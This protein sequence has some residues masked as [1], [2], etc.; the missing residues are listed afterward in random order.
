M[1]EQLGRLVRIIYA[2]CLVGATINH[3]RAVIMYGWLRQGLPLLTAIYW[4][5]LTFLDPVAAAFLFIRPKIGIVLTIAIIVSD[6]FHNLW[7]RAGHPV[8]GSLYTDVTNSPFMISQLTFLLFVAITAPIA[9]KA[10]S[11]S[12]AETV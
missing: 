3:V 8:T 9:W 7:F 11:R 4:S 10:C 12:R 5:S 2:L 6:V 1:M